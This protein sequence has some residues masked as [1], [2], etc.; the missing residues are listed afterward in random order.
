[1]MKTKP[2]SIFTLFIGILAYSQTEVYFKYDEAGNQK[3]RGTDI[4]ANRITN[5]ENKTPLVET[6]ATPQVNEDDL[7]LS[8]VNIYPVPV[9]TILTIEWA[10]EVDGLIQNVSLYEHSTVHWA[11]QR[12]N[13]PELNRKVEIDMT[14]YYMG[15]YIVR[16]Q[17]TDG[18]VISKNII[19]Q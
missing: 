17:L 7:F 13:K 19:K 11:F 12:E 4:N 6:S 3:Y 2:L 5:G 15:V 10:E 14:G 16:F 18:R 9:K 1:M 8:K